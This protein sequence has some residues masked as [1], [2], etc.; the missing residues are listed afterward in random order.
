ML[1]INPRKYSL[2]FRKEKKIIIKKHVKRME[3]QMQKKGA[4]GKSETGE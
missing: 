2:M 3:V 4:R 1:K